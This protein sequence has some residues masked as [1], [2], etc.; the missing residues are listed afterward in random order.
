MSPKTVSQNS[1]RRK[2]GNEVREEESKDFTQKTRKKTSR[3]KKCGVRKRSDEEKSTNTV[4][5]TADR[6][7]PVFLSV[8]LTITVR[9]LQ[10]GRIMVDNGS[11]PITLRILNDV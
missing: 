10:T 2:K 6:I 8:Y 9:W 1:N 3:R 7:P 5:E 11:R 4:R